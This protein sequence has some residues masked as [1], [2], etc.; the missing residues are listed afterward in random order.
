MGTPSL[1]IY[2]A[3]K[4]PYLCNYT[5]LDKNA[6][7]YE[8]HVDVSERINLCECDIADV[9]ELSLTADIVVMDPPWY[10]EHNKMFIG[11]GAKLCRQQ[12]IVMCVTPPLFTRPSARDEYDELVSYIEGLGLA[13]EKYKNTC[14]R[15]AT[16]PFE[17]NTLIANGVQCL[18][19]DW[20]AGDLLVLRK[21]G[22]WQ[23]TKDS[24]PTVQVQSTGARF[25][26]DW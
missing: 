8:K 17:R 11:M 22:D 13:V 9:F 21:T 1:F 20:R 23:I 18:P 2:F 5:L 12:S 16:P 14:I 19:N 26:L 7:L 10:L 24:V 4:W 25:V 6:T 15:Y 3:N